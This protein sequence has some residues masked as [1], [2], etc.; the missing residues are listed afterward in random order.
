M[1][2]VVN[3]GVVLSLMLTVSTVVAPA[4]TRAAPAAQSSVTWPIRASSNG[5]YL[6]DGANKPFFYFA[7]TPWQMGVHL[8]D[9][10]IRAYL[11]DRRNA[12]V[13]VVQ[14]MALPW[15]DAPQT[16]AWTSNGANIYGQRPF[17]N[18]NDFATY[19]PNYFDR[20]AFV[21]DEA[22]A[23]GIAVAFAPF[24]PGCC[25]ESW[26]EEFRANSYDSLRA[27]GRFIGE[28]F[29]QKDN[30]IWIMGG[31]RSPDQNTDDMARYD[32]MIAEIVSRD[33]DQ[34][35]TF[36]ASAGEHP[37]LV[38]RG[39]QTLDGVYTYGPG[40]NGPLHHYVLT[41]DAYN[42]SPAQPSILLE[43][44]YENERDYQPWQLR[45]QA[46]WTVLSG[47][48]GHA[49][50]NFYWNLTDD[51]DWR[52]QLHDRAFEQLRFIKPLFESLQWWTLV[53]DQTHTWVTA[54]YGAFQS[55]EQDADSGAD[56]VTAAHAPDRRLLVAYLPPTGQGSRSITVDLGQF[57]AGNIRGVWFNPYA[58]SRTDI[59]TFDNAGWRAFQSPGD[60]GDGAN[61]WVLILQANGSA[62]APTA[63]AAAAP[64]ATAQPTSAPQPSACGEVV[65]HENWRVRSV[66]SE[67]L[68]SYNA[69]A[70]AF[71]DVAGSAWHTAWIDT[72]P[73]PPHELIVNMGFSIVIKCVGF[74]PRQDNPV[75]RI[76]GY[77]FYASN[78]PND[79]GQP[80]A[81]GDLNAGSG[82]MRIAFE[83]KS[84]QYLRLVVN[85]T[86]LGEP[87]A[88]LAELNVFSSVGQAGPLVFAQSAP[89]PALSS[90]L[91]ADYLRR[92]V[93][94]RRT[95]LPLLAH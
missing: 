21:I 55:N 73:N 57:S 26:I 43:G 82:E 50:G 78:D 71:D 93:A 72:V 62:P 49:Y 53:P 22:R 23:R 92:F 40:Q 59:G 51:R 38:Q 88:A 95:Y 48:S 45:R 56:Y 14:V 28:R 32:A 29:G 42:A 87:V 27:Y 76:K 77:V 12:G 46:Y 64:T 61:D 84:A 33:R 36:H 63:T 89:M 13:N 79:W 9:A 11:D 44:R 18:E 5:R 85:S 60:N 34:L 83:H 2:T 35:A 47:A 8:N 31:D 7:T 74:L 41:L 54:G 80:V 37:R 20:I 70:Y 30:L 25:G 16:G 6:V 15:E 65:K 81:S 67:E 17:G 94:T 66:S 69:A 10:D 19:N 86:H 4:K 68:R 90:A 52:N 39:W 58:N 75:G 24:W 91:A 3:I 1:Q